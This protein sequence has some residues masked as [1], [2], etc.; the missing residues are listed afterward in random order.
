M[1]HN[2]EITNY[3]SNNPTENSLY[4]LSPSSN[5]DVTIGSVITLVCAPGTR[6]NGST[7]V[8]CMYFNA[9]NGYWSARNTTLCIRTH[10]LSCAPVP[11]I[12]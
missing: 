12:D 3:C 2:A 4:L 6:P 11:F 9:T 8:T 10:P 7:T 5:I 1:F